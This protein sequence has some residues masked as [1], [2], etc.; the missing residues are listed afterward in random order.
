M[1]E[2]RANLLRALT[3]R[4]SNPMASDTPPR[5]FRWRFCVESTDG[6]THY[7]PGPE[8]EG[9]DWIGTKAEARLEADRRAAEWEDHP[10]YQGPFSI[11][12]ERRGTA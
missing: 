4:G 8:G 2:H 7:L 10:L 5:E 11:V 12:M 3:V 6:S 1:L 9:E